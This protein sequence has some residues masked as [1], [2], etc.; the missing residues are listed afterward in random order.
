MIDP[1]MTEYDDRESRPAPPGV[2]ELLTLEEVAE[3]AGQTIDWAL[4]KVDELPTIRYEGGVYVSS[5]G[6]RHWL[7]AGR[8]TPRETRVDISKPELRG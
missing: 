5:L 1:G 2:L 8:E 4:A 7:R 3:L 6:L